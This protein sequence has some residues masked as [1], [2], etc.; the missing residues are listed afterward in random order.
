MIHYLLTFYCMYDAGF[1]NLDVKDCSWFVIGKRYLS[2]LLRATRLASLLFLHPAQFCP[3]RHAVS[4]LNIWE[5][6]KLHLLKHNCMCCYFLTY[7][8]WII[9][10]EAVSVW[11]N[12]NRTQFC[13]LNSRIF[14]LANNVVMQEALL[15]R[16]GC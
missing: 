4:D 13:L 8:V 9:L 14:Y 1:E 15:R 16:R 6:V 3:C 12:I 5:F 2:S 11:I 7:A 10:S